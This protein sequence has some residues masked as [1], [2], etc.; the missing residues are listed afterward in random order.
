MMMH[1][2]YM[3]VGDSAAS[4]KE[5]ITNVSCKEKE[6]YNAFSQNFAIGRYSEWHL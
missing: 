3:D 1:H 6:H 5:S 4:E 2:S